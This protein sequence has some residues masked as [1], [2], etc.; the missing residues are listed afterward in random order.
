MQVDFSH[1]GLATPRVRF[2]WIGGC[3]YYDLD[4]RGQQSVIT[5]VDIFNEDWIAPLQYLSC[6]ANTSDL[7]EIC[8]WAPAEDCPE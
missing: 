2:L 1:G 6:K 7:F 5:L 3:L 8:R 4:I